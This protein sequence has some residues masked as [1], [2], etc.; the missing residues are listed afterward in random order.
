MILLS[1][2]AI[3]AEQVWQMPLLEVFAWIES[4]L[5]SEGVKTPQSP[6]GVNNVEVKHESYVFTR[7]G[8]IK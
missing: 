4:Y 1:K 8:K 3:T 6:A 2:F 5:E 7:R